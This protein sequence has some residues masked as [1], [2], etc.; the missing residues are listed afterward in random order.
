MK[1]KKKKILYLFIIFITTLIL[2][3]ILNIKFDYQANK[4]A[5]KDQF[6]SKIFP[7][8]DSLPDKFKSTLMIYS[9]KRSFNNLFNDYNVKFL[10]QTEYIQLDL[11]KFKTSFDKSLSRT[12][13][14]EIFQDNLLL[15]S[16]SGEFYKANLLDIKNKNID[17][18]S[19]KIILKN[20]KKENEDIVINDILVIEDKIFVLKAT[21]NNIQNDNCGKLEI[22]YSNIRDILKFNHFKTFD[23][24]T[25]ANL[26]AGGMQKYYYNNKPG[27]L[28][29]TA[30]SSNDPLTSPA[31]ND[32]TIFGK[33]IFVNSETKEVITIS[34]G[35]RNPQGLAVKENIILSTEHGP[36]GGDEL[37]KIV[38][39]K[40]YG[41]PISSYGVP[42][43]DRNEKNLKFEKSHVHKGFQEP[44][45]VFLSSV[46]ISELIFLPNS[47]HSAWKDNVIVSS[48]NGRSLFRI[49]FSDNNYDKVLYIE[50]IFIGERIRDLKYSSNQ[51]LIV[52]ALEDTG[53]LGVLDIK[54]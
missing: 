29:S 15:V 49:K 25:G 11:K 21:E 12:F 27:I 52:L 14:I 4:I 42:Y 34:K 51:N 48:L 53:V 54:K 39:G 38:Y 22:Y 28:I 50:K 20:L 5:Y 46:G 26:A 30:G 8:F 17:K 31:Q 24:C 6:Q 2:L 35:H 43:P 40:N 1:F 9:G 23:E 32:N 41:W 13:F 3:F 36:K 33:I 19:E 18:I 47:F 16:K 7:L 37:N 44:I 10:P 45:Y